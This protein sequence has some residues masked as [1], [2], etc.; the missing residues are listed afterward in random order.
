MRLAMLRL[1]T[2]TPSVWTVVVIRVRGVAPL[3]CVSNVRQQR[4]HN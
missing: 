3:L 1:Y 4:H 2:T